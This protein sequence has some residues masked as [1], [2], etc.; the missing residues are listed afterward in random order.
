MIRNKPFNDHATVEFLESPRKDFD[1]KLLIIWHNASIHNC[2]STKSFL[3]NSTDDKKRYLV[4]KPTY[5]PELN[6]DEQV[7]NYLK[8]ITIENTCNRNIKELK[9]KR[10][11]D[12]LMHEPT[13]LL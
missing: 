3:E 2:K 8:E 7:W 13:A 1:R 6:H 10:V 12:S 5:T 4:Q 9:P 11:Y